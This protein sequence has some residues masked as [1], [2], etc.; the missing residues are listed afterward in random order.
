VR[1]RSPI[2]VIGAVVRLEDARGR[3]V[4]LRQLGANVNVG[5]CGP[6]TVNL[7]VREPGQYR[8]VVRFSDGK[9]KTWDV[10]LRKPGMAKID[11]RRE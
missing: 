3:V 4:A 6:N 8:L 5:C 7:A 11:A 10:D 1:V 2:G 9:A